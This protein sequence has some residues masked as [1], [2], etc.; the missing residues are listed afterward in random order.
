MDA[1]VRK[2]VFG[3][4]ELHMKEINEEENI[5][6]LIELMKPKWFIECA[7]RAWRDASALA[8]EE[9]GCSPQE[10]ENYLR[11]CLSWFEG[12]LAR[13]NPEYVAYVQYCGEAFRS[14]AE[15]GAR[16]GW[17][18]VMGAGSLLG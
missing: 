2:A 12:A 15:R 5:N 3:R 11:P 18:A 14:S 17:G 10:M 16:L 1:S 13:Y 7:Y 9:I 6:R 4:I 8:A